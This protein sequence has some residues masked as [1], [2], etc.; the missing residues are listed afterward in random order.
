MRGFVV[1]A[2]GA[3]ASAALGIWLDRQRVPDTWLVA[4]VIGCAAIVLTAA[5]YARS[6]A[7]QTPS[8]SPLT[9]RE[10]ESR[11]QAL[12]TR[13]LGEGDPTHAFESEGHEPGSHWYIGGGKRPTSDEAIDLCRI[14]GRKLQYE[15]LATSP[16][17]ARVDND[18]DRW[19][20]YLVEVG[21]TTPEERW[22]SSGGGC[23]DRHV[24]H[25]RFL[26]QA[27][28]NGCRKLLVHEV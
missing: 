5:R 4:I 1:G 21:E 27:C 25:F 8:P 3:V 19:L 22:I 18:A 13:N 26:L 11:F 7:S 14:A 24:Y 17:L 28:V 16:R 23:P 10:L 20:W 9:W 15:E 12:L 6:A 2:V